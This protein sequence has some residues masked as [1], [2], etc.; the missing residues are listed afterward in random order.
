MAQRQGVLDNSAAGGIPLYVAKF[1][2]TASN[3]QARHIQNA[4]SNQLPPKAA[5]LARAFSTQT[6]AGSGGYWLGALASCRSTGQLVACGY[7]GHSSGCKRRHYVT[8][9]CYTEISSSESG[10]PQNFLRGWLH[11]PQGW[12][13]ASQS[14]TPGPSRFL[15]WIGPVGSESWQGLGPRPFL[16]NWMRRLTGQRASSQGHVSK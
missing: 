1:G 5:S 4:Q 9:H 14:F 10:L 3:P 6:W 15:N 12:L 13:E 7:Q 2:C 11:F 16:R 8:T